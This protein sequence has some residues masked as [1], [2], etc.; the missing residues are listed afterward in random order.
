MALTSCPD[1][2]REVSG[3]ATTCPQCGCPIAATLPPPSASPV[4]P[5]AVRP[6][7]T[8]FEQVGCLLPLIILAIALVAIILFM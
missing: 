8:T 6:V 5:V 7:T 1:C 2:G 4:R 3:Q